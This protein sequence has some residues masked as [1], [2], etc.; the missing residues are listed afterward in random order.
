MN[1]DMRMD[2]RFSDCSSVS[3]THLEDSKV[4]TASETRKKSTYGVNL[5][6][7]IFEFLF[8]R[9]SKYV[10][11]TESHAILNGIQDEIRFA[12][13]PE[14]TENDE[15]ISIGTLDVDGEP[16]PPYIHPSD[17]KQNVDHAEA[18]TAAPEAEA[19]VAPPSDAN[20]TIGPEYERS[21]RLKKRKRTDSNEI[22][23]QEFGVSA[24]KALPRSEHEQQFFKVW[25][26]TGHCSIEPEK[27]LTGINA[28]SK[29][30]AIFSGKKM[31]LHGARHDEKNLVTSSVPVFTADVANK[32]HQDVGGFCTLN[33]VA[34]ALIQLNCPLSCEQYNAM[35]SF[36]IKSEGICSL[37][38]VIQKLKEVG[39]K[40][41]KFKGVRSQHLLQK[42]R[43]Q[44]EGVFVIV[45]DGSH[46]LTWHAGDQTILDSDPRFPHPLSINDDTLKL[47]MPRLFVDFA[48]RIYPIKNTNYK[49]RKLS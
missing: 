6:L 30:D 39:M 25:W 1:R 18:K 19:I 28:E 33:A 4:L 26:C 35:R 15:T 34:N 36:Q 42:M 32:W 5:Q 49:L 17:C 48:Y 7:P 29:R 10:S 38:D 13:P 41:S 27:N 22:S 44:N 8:A 24:I 20:I 43:E 9:L 40:T 16:S 47:L 21:S 46:V 14:Y 37:Q 45:Y 12:A 31:K 2:S 11:E 3:P 23:T